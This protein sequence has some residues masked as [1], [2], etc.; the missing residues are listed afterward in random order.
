MPVHYTI[1][2]EVVNLRVD[3]PQPTDTF[4]VDTNIWYWLAYNRANQANQPP[5]RYQ[6]RDYP[7]YLGN[8]HTFGAKFHWVG[9]SLAELAHLIEK[10]LRMI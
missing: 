1:Q 5:K 7:A 3:T 4:W 8:A 2:A 10:T 9:L 6:I